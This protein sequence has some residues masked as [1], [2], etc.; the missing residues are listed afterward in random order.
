MKMKPGLLGIVACIV[1]LPAFA[2][3]IRPKDNIH[4]AMT[5]LAE[6]CQHDAAGAGHI[7]CRGSYGELARLRGVASQSAYQSLGISA[8]W[9][10]DPT[11][12]VVLGPS[13]IR[14]GLEAGRFCERRRAEA[15]R[16]GQSYSLAA[17]GLVCASHAGDLQFFHAMASAPPSQE[18]AEETRQKA[19]DWAVFA[20]SVA[21]RRIG[22]D[23]DYCTTV[24]L[25]AGSAGAS[26]A[27]ADFP[28]CSDRRIDRSRVIPAWRV[29][30]L[31]SLRCR[32]IL[33]AIESLDCPTVSEG[34]DGDLVRR[35]A[36]GAVVHMIQDSYSQSHAVRGPIYG[37]G[38]PA[39]PRA[40]VFCALPTAFYFY[41]AQ[42]SGDHA[43]ADAVPRLDEGCGPG[44]AADDA[45]TA[46]AI[47]M[48]HMR[49]RTDPR[50]F[51]CYLERRV[52]GRAR[53]SYCS[54][55][56]AS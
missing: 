55:S 37:S 2:Y 35:S 39:E 38:N 30:T 16:R 17:S 15:E 51:G 5:V 56:T 31:F 6:R 41:N 33:R 49:H 3:S 12:M 1:S 42:D 46:S 21:T 50:V 26:L 4:E 29:G 34:D 11:R 20:Y 52:L 27:P 32:S 13:A 22:A 45:I 10:D 43:K 28:A 14:F 40:A 9:P 48:W 18:S 7:D 36:A 25:Q 19:L 23:Q 44:A 47:A 54:G 53:H 24:R 8:H